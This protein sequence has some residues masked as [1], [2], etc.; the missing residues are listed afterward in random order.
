M[1][2]R[3]QQFT[4]TDMLNGKFIHT[5]LGYGHGNGP[6]IRQDLSD[7]IAIKSV[8]NWSDLMAWIDDD[9]MKHFHGSS[10]RDLIYSVKKY[11]QTVREY[12]ALLNPEKLLESVQIRSLPPHPPACVPTIVCLLKCCHETSENVTQCF[13]FD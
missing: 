11:F 8:T 13:V 6:A 7:T 10:V 5:A 4:C 12:N 3:D 2:E 1:D 9:I